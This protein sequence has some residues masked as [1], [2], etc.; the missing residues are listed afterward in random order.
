MRVPVGMGWIAVACA[1][2]LIIFLF[3]EELADGQTGAIFVAS[4]GLS[5]VAA[6]SMWLASITVRELT[7]RK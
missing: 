2:S 4:I 7:E 6:A 1:S 5:S 3:R